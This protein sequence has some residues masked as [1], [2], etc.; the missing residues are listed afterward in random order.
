MMYVGKGWVDNNGI[1]LTPDKVCLYDINN[2]S[3]SSSSL[4]HH[5]DTNLIERNRILS[6]IFIQHDMTAYDI[7]YTIA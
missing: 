3:S 7:T 4:Y 5:H 2:S 1:K 6:G